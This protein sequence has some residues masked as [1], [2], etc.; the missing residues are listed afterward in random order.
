[1]DDLTLSRSAPADIDVCGRIIFDAFR[2]VAEEHGFPPDFASVDEG[3]GV[4]TAVISHPDF[5]GVVAELAGRVVGSNFL[6]ERSAIIGLG[7]ITVDP[8]AQNGQIGRRLMIDALDRCRERRVPGVRLL[9][10]AYHNRSLSLYTKLGFELREPCVTMQGPSIG[11]KV[12]GYEVRAAHED[13]LQACDRLCTVVHGH[14]RFGEVLDA[15]RQGAARVVEHDGRITGYCTG[16]SFLAHAVGESN[17]DLK[18]LIGAATEF[19]GP[20]FMLPARN[21]EL[22]RWCMSRGLRVVH[23][24]NLMSMGLYNE[25][26][27]SYLPSILY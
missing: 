21:G 11:E 14:D 9:Q 10:A 1:M 27:G 6:D 4:A 25:P 15:I 3:V 12:P 19:G 17:D 24:M 26:A 20:G 23:V 5:Y 8:S 22:Y 2:A 7:P 18:A 16:I 13:D